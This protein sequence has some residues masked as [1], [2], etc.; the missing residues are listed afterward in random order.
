MV[1]VQAKGFWVGRGVTR[2]EG[3]RRLITGNLRAA[4]LGE[5]IQGSNPKA[6]ER[7]KGMSI[8]KTQ[9]YKKEKKK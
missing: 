3:G 4:L 2:G 6:N 5:E 1:S 8:I 7:G 9:G